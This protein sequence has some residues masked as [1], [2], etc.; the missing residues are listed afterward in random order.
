MVDEKESNENYEDEIDTNENVIENSNEEKIQD[1][2][3]EENKDNITEEK[4]ED[5]EITEN[6]EE[7]KSEEDILKKKK[8]KE[9]H[10]K[11]DISNLTTII[12]TSICLII[13][14]TAI[15]LCY[16]YL[17]DKIKI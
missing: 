10:A 6:A 11:E 7:T 4:Q 9:K 13:S 8:K 5:N 2:V 15:V 17:T 1:E 3:I 16:L 14:I 12:I